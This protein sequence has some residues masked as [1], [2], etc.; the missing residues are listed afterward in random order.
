MRRRR[1]GVHTA[2]QGK[3][4]NMEFITGNQ[5]VVRGALKAGCNYVAGYPIT[6]ASSILNECVTA[7]DN[8]AGTIIQTEDE[9]A[10]IGQCIAASMAGAKP[11]TATSG[12]G[13]CLYSEN[14]GFAQMVEAPLVIVDCQRMGPATG[15]ATATGDGDVIFAGNVTPGGYPLPVFAATDAVSAY[16]LTYLSFNIAERLRTPVILLT[17]RDIALT[18][19]SVDLDAVQLPPVI[20][21]QWADP[22]ASFSPYE[23]DSIENVPDFLP[24]GGPVPVRCTGSIHGPDGLLTNDRHAIDRKLAHLSAK[25]MDHRHELTHVDAD[26]DPQADTLILSY[27]VADG[28][29]RDAVDELR[30]QGHRI[31][32]LTLYTLWP[33]PEQAIRNAASVNVT[34]IIVPELNIGLYAEQL[35]RVIHTA[36][37][38]SITRIDGGLIR[39]EQIIEAYT[40]APCQ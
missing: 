3:G 5:A 20:K 35:R 39:P 32:H 25:I 22:D 38:Q 23:Y 36:D 28:A 2:T 10:A 24:I 6:P 18:R 29:A 12:P 7:F 21:R 17:S 26:R 4:V 40:M 13:L 1:H 14:I 9:I 11:L 30:S 15:G 31:T 34:R 37:I 16:K 27:G 8:G 19:Q 33:M